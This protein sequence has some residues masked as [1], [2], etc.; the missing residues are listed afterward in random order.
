MEVTLS[1]IKK[2]L[3]RTNS[4]GMEARIQVDLEHKGEINIQSE[5]KEETRI[6]KN[7]D[8]IRRLWD[9]SKHA[10]IGVP[11]GEEEEQE[12]ENL[13]EKIM[14]ENLPNLVKE[15]DMQVQ[16]AQ[17]PKQ[18]GPKENHTKTHHN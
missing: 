13:F 8:C 1:E 2:N 6:K 3:Q 10:N 11:E 18:V 9:I 12:I 15:I 5:Q 17:S 14:K 4:E 16:E 7:K